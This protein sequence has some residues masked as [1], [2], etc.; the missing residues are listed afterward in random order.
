M[1]VKMM[2]VPV[3]YSE[4]NNNRPRISVPIVVGPITYSEYNSILQY[5]ISNGNY[6][7][8]IQH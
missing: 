3:T 4:Y 5:I 6:I 1:S 8:Q 2:V 7:H